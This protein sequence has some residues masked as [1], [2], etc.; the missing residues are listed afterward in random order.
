MFD[1]TR[2]KNA[3]N[4]GDLPDYA[5]RNINSQYWIFWPREAA[6]KGIEK[7][8]SYKLVQEW[9]SAFNLTAS[10]RRD[11]DILRPFGDRN[12]ALRKHYVNGHPQDWAILVDSIMSLKQNPGGKHTAWI[13][14]NCGRTNGARARWAYAQSMIEHGLKLDGF[15]DCF[16]KHLNGAPWSDKFGDGLI[17][18][19]KF[20]LAFENSL[21]CND[22]MSEK[23]WRNS[24]NTGA[25]P[26]IYGPHPDDVKAVAPPKSYIHAEDFSSAEELVAYLDY[27]DSNDTA[28]LEYHAWRSEELPKDQITELGGSMSHTMRMLCNMCDVVT[29]RKQQG[30]P[31]RIIKSVASWWWVNVHDDLCTKDYAMPEWVRDFPPVTMENSFDELKLKFLPEDFQPK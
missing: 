24:L 7:G 17:A 28:Y 1:N 11:S 15:G 10:Y 3:K 5:N 23:F 9:D 25:V 19:Y 27:L 6:S 26:V 4:L 18:K 20:Y 16:G 12:N 30:F 14:S 31:R 21:H 29:T 13:V 2:Y 22:Y 8:T